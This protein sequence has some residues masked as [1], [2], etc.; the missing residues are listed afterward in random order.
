MK[1]S[2]W[3]RSTFFSFFTLVCFY[4]TEILIIFYLKTITLVCFYLTEILINVNLKQ[5][6][7][8]VMAEYLNHFA[9]LATN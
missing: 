6:H 1:L 8:L 2:N 4:L 3:K 5:F 9:K 7:L